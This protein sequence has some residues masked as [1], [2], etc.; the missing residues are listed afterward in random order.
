MFSRPGHLWARGRVTPDIMGKTLQ[1][2]HNFRILRTASSIL[3]CI[4]GVTVTVSVPLVVT[5][6]EDLGSPFAFATANPEPTAVPPIP[7]SPQ[8]SIQSPL[9]LS[10]LGA[11]VMTTM[12]SMDCSDGS[13]DGRGCGCGRPNQ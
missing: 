8:S 10:L 9:S 7:S 11:M 12:A 6:E 2:P 4:P 5:T 3:P 1:R 13:D